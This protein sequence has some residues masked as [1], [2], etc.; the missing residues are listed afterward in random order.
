MDTDI[1]A[2]V[3]KYGYKNLHV[4][5]EEL[6]REEYAYFQAKF[7]VPLATPVPV[8]VAPL[9][10]SH[11]KQIQRK[12]KTRVKKPV[13]TSEVKETEDVQLSLENVEMK[14]VIVTVSE[15]TFRDPNEGISEGSS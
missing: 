12:E 7:Q 4:R 14:D 13:A 10:A 3:A 1:Y 6:M 15:K 9:V 5:L 8:A 11:V 2:L